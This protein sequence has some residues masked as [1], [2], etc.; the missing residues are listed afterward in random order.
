MPDTTRAAAQQ[1]RTPPGR[2]AGRARHAQE[3]TQAQ[4]AADAR[5]R[6]AE[7]LAADW[8][9]LEARVRAQFPGRRDAADVLAQAGR[10]VE[11]LRTAQAAKA[12]R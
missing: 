7:Q 8:I 5:T 11:Q 9:I 10:I 4:A 3:G 2:P 12:T 6:A 1:H